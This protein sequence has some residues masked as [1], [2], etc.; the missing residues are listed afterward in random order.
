MFPL[1]NAGVRPNGFP[2]FFYLF[3]PVIPAKA[4]IQGFRFEY[5]FW[6]PGQ[7]R[8]DKGKNRVIREFVFF[9]GIGYY[10]S[11]KQIIKI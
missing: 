5:V 6:I 4:G 7:D 3:F 11:K 1:S 9:E 8:D 10:K 2:L